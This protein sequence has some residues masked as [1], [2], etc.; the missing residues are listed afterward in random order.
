MLIYIANFLFDDVDFDSWGIDLSVM[1]TRRRFNTINAS[2]T[3]AHN[4]AGEVVSKQKVKHVHFTMSTNV[5]ITYTVLVLRCY[6]HH[7]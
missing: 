1:S 3:H 6:S 4:I 7:K 2:L 5:I